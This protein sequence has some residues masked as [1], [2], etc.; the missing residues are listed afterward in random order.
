[1]PIR[2]QHTLRSPAFALLLLPAMGCGRPLVGWPLADTGVQLDAT[3][4]TVSATIPADVSTGA[5]LNAAVIVVFSEE[6][7]M[8]T[9]VDGCV[10]LTGGAGEPLLGTITPTV[11]AVVFDPAADL[12]PDT[13]YTGA[14][15]TTVTDLA[16]NNMSEVYTWTFSTGA[17]TDVEPPRVTSTVPADWA[18]DVD[19]GVT[20]SATF[21]EQMDPATISADTFAL[22]GPGGVS[23]GGVVTFDEGTHTASFDPD[24]D[25]VFG[26]TYAGRVTSGAADL[27]G[28]PM[29]EYY[30]WIF[31][32]GVLPRDLEPVDLRSLESFVAVAGAG[33]TTSNV[34]GTTTLNGNV[35]LSPVGTCLGDGQPCTETNPVIN[36]EL[37]ANDAEGVAAQAK[38]DLDLAYTDAMG[39]PPGESVHDLSG[40]TFGPGV[41]TS[42]S[43]LILH[44][45]ETVTLD[46]GGDANAVWIFQVPSAM[47]IDD[48]TSV[49]LVNG[50]H[51]ENVFWAIGT[52][53]SLGSNVSFQG[54]ILA[55]ASST[56]DANSA[57]VGRVFSSTGAVSL[58]SDNIALPRP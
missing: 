10:L 20:L 14:V 50:A 17:W 49:L 11:S 41:Y 27:A 30:V 53:S 51:A 58:I 54:T 55:Q 35:G 2:S 22:T 43:S 23:L 7:D 37:Y 47:T 13:E 45:G 9:L 56:V 1:M 26:T 25:L 31:S 42:N 4:P 38:L 57:I 12:L 46:G 39:R 40:E 18:N 6:M 3:P 44:A 32:T 28:N 52:S 19:P 5:S 34:L 29:V 36:A 33:L 21:S 24:A 8:S 48:D 15:L 16:G